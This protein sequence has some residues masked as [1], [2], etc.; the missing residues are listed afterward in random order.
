M[1]AWRVPTRSIGNPS[2]VFKG[3]LL[4]PVQTLETRAEPVRISSSEKSFGRA[5]VGFC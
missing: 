5:I 3:H 2:K 4:V 1:S